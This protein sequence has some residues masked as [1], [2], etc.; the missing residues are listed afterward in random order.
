MWPVIGDGL[1][2][3]QLRLADMKVAKVVAAI[4]TVVQ[5]WSDKS[6]EPRRRARED[7]VRATGFSAAAVDRSFDVELR[8]YRS[9][10]LWRTLRRELGSPEVLDGFHADG[11]LAGAALAVGPRIT[12]AVL[13]GNV[14][15]LPALSLVRALLV[16]S[17]VIAKVASGEP[18]FAAHFVATIAEV[19]PRLADAILVTYWDRHD[20]ASLSGALAQADAVIAYGGEDACAAVRA[21]VAPHQRYIEHGHKLSV[22]IVSRSYLEALG[23]AEVARRVAD[24][25]STFNQHACI[26]PQAY[27]VEAGS[28]EVRAFA[29]EVAGALEHHAR[30]C[31][32]GTLDAVDASVLQLRRAEAAWGAAKSDGCDVWHAAG[33][34]WTVI[35]TPELAMSGTGNRVLHLVPVA[36][37]DDAVRRLEPIC[38]YLQN[39]GLGALGADFRNTAPKLAR[40]GAC[41]VSEPGRMAE[42]SMMWRHDGVECISRLV[43]WC[44]VEM[45]REIE[46]YSGHG[47]RG[48]P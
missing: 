35:L 3:A 9:E 38:R 11:D 28:D 33:L 31:P 29:A 44:D 10:F 40:A 13:T 45:H 15:G 36:S 17:A 23:P 21:R 43:R 1:R 30:S 27:L 4:D 16:K 14:P 7:V 47:Q 2:K 32:L 12:L 18:T 39:V 37:L 48:V 8:N 46:A 19:E 26:A 22:G 5:R 24:D 34:D 25:V 20:E 42:P 41:R 6:F